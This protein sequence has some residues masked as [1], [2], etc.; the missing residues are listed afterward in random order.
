MQHLL[1]E[2]MKRYLITI[3]ISSCCSLA[4][5]DYVEYQRIWNR[6]DRDI[7]SGAFSD[8]NARLDTV[9]H[10]YSF[11]YARHCIKALQLCNA[12]NDLDRA[13]LWL[14]KCFLQGV[15]LWVIRN[16][17]LTKT[18]FD[19]PRTCI[20]INRYDSLRAKYFSSLKKELVAVIDSLYKIDQYRTNRVN[21]G[22]FLLKP[23]YGLQWLRN[24]RKQF[25][26]I[27]SLT[28][29]YGFPGERLIGLPPY[30]QDSLTAFNSIRNYGAYLSDHRAYL[31]LIHY[32]SHPHRDMNDLLISSLKQGLIEPCQFASINDFM[33]RWGKNRFNAYPFYNAWHNDPDH[34]HLPE[35]NKRREAIGLNSFYMQEQ[36][37]QIRFNRRKDKTAD[38]SILLE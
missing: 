37:T 16:D 2:H 9:Y 10:T 29:T 21:D 11:I 22:F 3:W 17:K 13:G 15:P 25:E 38:S 14:E 19:H 33:A 27:R 34:S 26:I 36:Y 5:Q 32:Y 23:V 28:V 4:G 6:V 20:I 18:V 12:Q 31:M 24:N 30:F 7:L 1:F 8:A 35:I